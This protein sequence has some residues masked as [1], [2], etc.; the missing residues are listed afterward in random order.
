[1]L[2]RPGPKSLNSFKFGTFIGRFPSD[3][4]AS[5]TVKGLM[6]DTLKDLASHNACIFT[7]SLNNVSSTIMPYQ[8]IVILGSSLNKWHCPKY[9][10]CTAKWID[11][12]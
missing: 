3:G 8:D 4:A 7:S 12:E 5:M 1:M 2:K 6:A 9:E 11:P 10:D